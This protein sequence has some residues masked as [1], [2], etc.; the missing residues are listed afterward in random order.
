MKSSDILR[1]FSNADTGFVEQA[2]DENGKTYQ[3]DI[4][5]VLD[6]IHNGEEYVPDKQLHVKDGRFSR[7]MLLV[8]GAAACAVI[9]I[10]ALLFANRGDNLRNPE[11]NAG[12]SMPVEVMTNTTPTSANGTKPG[13]MEDRDIS[14]VMSWPKDDETGMTTEEQQALPS[15]VIR[16]MAELNASR[17]QPK[18]QYTEEFFKDHALIFVSTVFSDSGDLP[19]VTNVHTRGNTIEVTAERPEAREKEMQW[20]SIF[21]EVDLADLTMDT[22]EVVLHSYQT[23]RQ[24][25]DPQEAAQTTDTGRDYDPHE[26]SYTVVDAD[27]AHYNGKQSM[28]QLSVLHHPFDG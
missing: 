16:S 18:K 1:A 13:G 20:W 3:P 14:F 7:I 15:G 26:I 25:I 27:F 6:A 17:V 22:P 2:A 23:I 21:L 9:G 4:S 5:A 8:C 11:T 10:T 24:D 19:T 28:E 12:T